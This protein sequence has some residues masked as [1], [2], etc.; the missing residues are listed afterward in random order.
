MIRETPRYFLIYIGKM[1]NILLNNKI[2]RIPPN[3]RT[4]LTKF[5]KIRLVPYVVV[6][7]GVAVHPIYGSATVPS[8][9]SPADVTLPPDVT[10]PVSHPSQ[11][12]LGLTWPDNADDL[13]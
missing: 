10:W 13:A 5:T 4:V 1:I 2:G 11:P 8:L 9:F 3:Y 6:T 7:C 12:D